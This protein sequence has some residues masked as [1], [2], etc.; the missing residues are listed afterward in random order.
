MSRVST[1]TE[2][3]NKIRKIPEQDKSNVIESLAVTVEKN[4]SGKESEV[5]Y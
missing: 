1:N 4:R 5:L 3:S 2:L